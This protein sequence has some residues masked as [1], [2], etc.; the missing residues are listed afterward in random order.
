VKH[1]VLKIGLNLH[2]KVEGLGSGHYNT[3]VNFKLKHHVCNGLEFPKLTVIIWVTCKYY[4]LWK[5]LIVVE[6]LIPTC[7]SHILKK[8]HL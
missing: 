2:I 6:D 3:H 5:I 7:N 1:I 4:L 8:N